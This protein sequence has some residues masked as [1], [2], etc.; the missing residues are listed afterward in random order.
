MQAQLTKLQS[1]ATLKWRSVEWCIHIKSLPLIQMDAD[2]TCC[3]SLFRLFS[4][5]TSIAGNDITHT[6]FLCIMKML[7]WSVNWLTLSFIHY[8]DFM[9]W[10]T[11]FTKKKPHINSKCE[12]HNRK[13]SQLTALL[14]VLPAPAGQ[15]PSALVCWVLYVRMTSVPPGHD[16]LSRRVWFIL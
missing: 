14:S 15:R 1:I 3:F 2:A 4:L 16:G 9:P 6:T 8:T 10:L 12:F 5:T 11:W 13:A 7:Y